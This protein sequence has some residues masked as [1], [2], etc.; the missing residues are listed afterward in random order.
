VEFEVLNGENFKP[1]RCGEIPEDHPDFGDDVPDPTIDLL[2]GNDPVEL[3][4]ALDEMISSAVR[5]G[6][7]I[8]LTESMRALFIEYEEIWR[9]RLGSDPPVKISPMRCELKPGFEPYKASS[10]R[11]SPLAQE[12]MEVETERQIKWGFAYLNPSSQWA[13]SPFCVRKRVKEGE[14]LPPLID[15]MR[16]TVDLREVNRRTTTTVWPMPNLEVVLGGIAGAKCFALFDLTSGYWQFPLD[17]SCREMFSYIT[18]RG[19]FTPTRVP[20]GAAGSVAYVQAS[21]CHIL[22]SE[23]LYICAIPWIDDVLLWANSDKELIESSRKLFDRCKSFGL[24]LHAKKCQVY[25][26]SAIWCGRVIS[27]EGVAHDPSR[28]EALR[29]ISLPTTGADLQQFI[30]AVNWLRMTLPDYARTVAPLMNF[31]ETVYKK[32]KGK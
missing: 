10:R 21:M 15:L 13:S 9:I 14:N 30:C 23:L 11:Y 6:A 17:P 19:I 18:D 5:N 4:E 28:L 16:M 12:F 29:S 24:K 26:R 2:G 8:D 22:G 31:M 32:A 25:T 1:P 27:S 7:S 3:K 20:Q